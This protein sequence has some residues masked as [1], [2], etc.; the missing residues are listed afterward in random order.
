MTVGLLAITVLKKASTARTVTVKLFP[1]VN[2][3]AAPPRPVV[4]EPPAPL[5]LTNLVE[6]SVPRRLIDKVRGDVEVV[7]S[8]TVLPD[9]S[10]G[11]A[12]VQQSNQPLMNQ[13]V[14]DAVAQWRYA[15]IAQAR[16]HAVQ[17][18]MRAGE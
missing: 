7:V 4:V 18:L 13:T 1:A 2:A 8:F 15:P 10:V 3:V 17:L 14:L 12:A 16:Q 11:S 6:P 5:Q 9:G